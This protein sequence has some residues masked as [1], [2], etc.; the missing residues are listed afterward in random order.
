VKYVNP[1]GENPNSVSNDLRRLCSGRNGISAVASRFR[2]NQN[3]PGIPPDEISL[4][5]AG[6]GGIEEWRKIWRLEIR[7]DWK[8]YGEEWEEVLRD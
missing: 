7:Q 2:R 4:I 6:F 5:D 1:F 8:P 3:S